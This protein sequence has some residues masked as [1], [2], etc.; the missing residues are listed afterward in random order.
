M[1][2]HEPTNRIARQSKY[3]AMPAPGRCLGLS[4]DVASVINT[5]LSNDR[6]FSWLHGN[7]PKENRAQLLEDGLDEVVISLVDATKQ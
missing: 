7:T 6:R 3:Q 1:A 4:Y 2:R 5:N